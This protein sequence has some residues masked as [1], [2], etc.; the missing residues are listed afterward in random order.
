MSSLC[1][2]NPCSNKDHRPEREGFILPSYRDDPHNTTRKFSC[3]SPA[4]T[5]CSRKGGLILP[6][7]SSGKSMAKFFV[8]LVGILRNRASMIRKVSNPFSVNWHA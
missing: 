4:I 7:K 5:F 2:A 3:R 8:F 1:V 6:T